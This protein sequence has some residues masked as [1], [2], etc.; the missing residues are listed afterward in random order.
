MSLANLADIE[1]LERKD[2]DA[3]SR[4]RSS[5]EMLQHGAAL[6]P[7]APA[8]SFFLRAADFAHP[9]GWNHR[10]WF[11]RIT[12]AANMFRQLGVQKGDV[13]AC[14]LPNLPETHLTIWGGETAG[15]AFP[16]NP[17]LEAP[18]IAELLRTS[19]ARWLVTLA[20][21]E[22]PG[23]WEK[24]AEVVPEVPSLRGILAVD[25][26]HYID[27][28]AVRYVPLPEQ[29]GGIPVLDFKRSLDVVDDQALSFAPPAADDIASYFGTGGTTGMPK[30]ATR[31]HRTET[32]N[33]LELATML[34]G[35]LYGPGKTVFCGLPL[36]HVNGQLG[37]GLS[38]WSRGAHVLLG[39]PQGYRAPGLIE[40]FWEIVEHHRV[41]TFSGVPTIY[42]SLLNTPRT[43]RDLSSLYCGICGAAPIP[44]ELFHRFEEE[45]GVRI[46]EA[47]GLTESGCA[48]TANPTSGAAR[49]GSIGLRLPW[50]EIRVM[51]LDDHEQYVR[52]AIGDEVGVLALSGP[53]LF[54]GYLNPLH[55]H[56]VW[57][58]R[59]EADG[60][61]SRWLNT[62]DL[63]RCDADGYFWLA[64][65]KKDLIIRGGHNIDPQMIEKPLH[66][67][68]AVGMAAA[69]GRPDPHS[70]EVPVAYVQLRAGANVS[71]LL[72]NLVFARGGV[73]RRRAV[74][75]PVCCR[76]PVVRL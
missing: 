47:Y 60:T 63:G 48:A 29:L 26:Q 27:A 59:P 76:S 52:D 54:A 23:L 70:G 67:H 74:A 30:I 73:I 57:I 6:A 11:A 10:E 42:A 19:G 62:G 69:V 75:E 20:P 21:A 34:G 53:N 32:S 44:E 1:K 64:G 72:S 31:T 12:Q 39:T 35:S 40:R 36:F 71:E 8:L 68:P 58:N 5:Y 13:V 51:I 61:S 14:V 65:R 55:N 50:Q 9:I 16:I 28:N 18:W 24:A 46:I 7:D 3:C 22:Q 37:T 45:T 56:S 2:P 41:V 15:I 49:V 17:L 33:A 43:G 25:M 38:P 66:R 4:L